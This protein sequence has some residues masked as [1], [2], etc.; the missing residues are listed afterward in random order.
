VDD[1]ASLDPEL[2][3]GL[4][5]LKNYTGDVETDL[6]LNFTVTEDG[7]LSLAFS[8]IQQPALIL[9]SCRRFRSSQNDRSSRQR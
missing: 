4:M 3:N 7:A 5:F 9:C 6:S 8:L 2:Y 1:L